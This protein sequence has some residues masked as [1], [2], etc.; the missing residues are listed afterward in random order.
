MQI[1]F[2]DTLRRWVICDELDSTTF[3]LTLSEV[4]A[5]IRE[6]FQISPSSSLVITYVDKDN[7][8]VTLGDDH[9]LVDACIV[10][11]LNPLRLN[12]DEKSSSTTT[13]TIR[14]ASTTTNTNVDTS[15]TAT[16]ISSY[17]GVRDI[18]AILKNIFP[19]AT[20]DALHN[21]VKMHS[22]YWN[23]VLPT[24]TLVQKAQEAFKQF[25]DGLT[26]QQRG[27][28]M[29]NLHN[30]P[31]SRYAYTQPPGLAA[32]LGS[33]GVFHRRV[34]CDGCGMNPIEGIRYKS[35]K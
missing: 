3:S 10:Q 5:K 33:R 28:D 31:H 1:K 18:E 16:G 26:S 29:S 9:D 2:N 8:V 23:P 11:H 15:A 21:F 4:E 20:T 32:S 34:Q 14:N 35:T 12:V 17:P 7:D 22:Q 19:Q 13:S 30:N 25:L 6:L 27:Q 24:D